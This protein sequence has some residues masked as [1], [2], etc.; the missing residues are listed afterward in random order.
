MKI[1]CKTVI[2]SLLASLVIVNLNLTSYASTLDE[3]KPELSKHDISVSEDDLKIIDKVYKFW[4]LSG[5]KIWTG[6]HFETTPIVIVF[7]GKYNIVIGHPNKIKEE[8]FLTDK[9]PILNKKAV[10]IKDNTFMG[11]GAMTSPDFN[12]VPT[13]FINTL[14]H[15]NEYIRDYAKTNNITYLLS[16]EK[17]LLEYMGTVL[18]ELFHSYQYNEKAKLTKK[19]SKAIKLTKIDFPYLN[20]EIDLLLG[21]EGQILAKIIKT[22][23][24]LKSESLFRDFVIVRSI[25]RSKMDSDFT[26]L[27]NYMELMEGLAQYVGCNLNYLE[28]A[29]LKEIDINESKYIGELEDEITKYLN[30]LHTPLI[31]RYMSYVY[32]SGMAQAYI[33]DKILPDWKKDFFIKHKSLEE[34]YTVFLKSNLDDETSKKELER[35]K[36]DYD[37]EAISKTISNDLYPIKEHNKEKFERYSLKKGTTYEFI[38]EGIKPKNVLIYAPVLLTEHQ[39]YRIF[40]SGATK[41]AYEDDENNELT[42]IEFQKAIPIFFNKE[43]GYTSFIDEEKSDFEIKADKVTKTEKETI[44]EGNVLLKTSIFTWSGSKAKIIKDETKNKNQITLIK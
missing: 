9:F 20:E 30:K 11:G 22:D 24:K 5:E 43:T 29:K 7:S 13:V 2:K 28:K 1:N 8:I 23:D 15:N 4:E 44:Y 35:I 19:S 31:T 10:L 18:H 12:G 25:R 6:A 32:Y 39:Q 14:T 26:R 16:Y 27:E 41:I 17:P 38:F 40:E 37:V 33:L 36:K 21:L 34:L 3:L 42:K